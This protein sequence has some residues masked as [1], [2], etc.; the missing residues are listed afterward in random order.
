MKTK[1]YLAKSNRAN[2]DHITMVRKT[3]SEFEVEVVEFKGGAYSHKPLLQCEML[4][5]L[6]ELDVSDDE[7][8]YIEEL[9]LGKGL[10]EQ[11]EAFKHKNKNK[12]DILIIDGCDAG[13][14]ASVNTIDEL[15]VCDDTDY[16]NY[17]VAL[18]DPDNSG[19][20]R[21]AIENRCGLSTTSTKDSS[22]SRYRLLLTKS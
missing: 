10:H 16:V 6:P 21:D 2:P 22:M 20:L 18:I 13:W 14:G 19:P 1:I 8:C 9:P 7:D 5:I 4:V 15:D 11:Y 3:L 17:S 12:C